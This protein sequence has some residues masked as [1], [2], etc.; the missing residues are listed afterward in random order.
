MLAGNYD[1]VI[2]LDSLDLYFW[3]RGAF[4]LTGVFIAVNYLSSG[5]WLA[6]S[7][8]ENSQG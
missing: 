8:W 5:L 6:N 4:A 1:A 3:R 2:Y 7:T